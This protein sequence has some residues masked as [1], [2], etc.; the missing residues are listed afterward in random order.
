MIKKYS[1][2]FVCIH[3]SARSQMAEAF[4]REI[5]G[6]YFTVASAGLEAGC[7]N[8]LVTRAMGEIGLDISAQSTDDIKS[9]IQR[10][11]RFDYV[12]TVCDAVNAQRC[13]IVPGTM[14]KLHWGFQD[15]AALSGD[16]EE[17][18]EQVRVIREQIR[19]QVCAFIRSC[20]IPIAQ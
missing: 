2:L 4:L 3:N 10:G 16:E 19:E 20:D 6:D 11:D 13:P 7:L 12:I 15:P 1:V 5:A 17:R 18:M 9:V 14:Q 8:P